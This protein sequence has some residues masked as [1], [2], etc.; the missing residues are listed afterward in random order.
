MNELKIHDLIVTSQLKRAFIR[1]IDRGLDAVAKVDDDLGHTSV[2][3]HTFNTGDARP[4]KEKLRA[5]PHH[6]RSF[7][8]KE[9]VD[10]YLR[11]G[12]VSKAH[13]GKGPWVATIV[14]VNKKE[15]FIAK[16][17]EGHRICQDYRKVNFLTL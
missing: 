8:E 9:E 13:P 14:I 17:V 1:V 10:I 7:A 16:L 11:L 12:I 5:L 15:T 2:V 3:E 6:R 4:I